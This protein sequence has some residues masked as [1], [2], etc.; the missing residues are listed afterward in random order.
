MAPSR[1]WIEGVIEGMSAGKET[2]PIYS[3]NTGFGS[4]AGRRA[5]DNPAD[6]AELSRRL[7]LADASGVGRNVDEEVVRATILIR[8]VSLTRGYSGIQ[9]SLVQGLIDMLNHDVYPAVPEFGSLGASGDLIPLAHIAIVLTGPPVLAGQSSGDDDPLD[10]GEAIVD[11]KVVT[12]VEAM[13]H[14]GLKRIPITAKDGLA[15]LNGT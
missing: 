12:G 6:A 11:G 8:I 7:I 13:A 5:F 2:A 14:A 4:L 3:I 10:S 15:L 1:E 9:L